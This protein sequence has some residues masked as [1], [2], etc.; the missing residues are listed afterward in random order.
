MVRSSLS[1]KFASCSG[2]TGGLV[3]TLDDDRS[4]A[5]ELRSMVL[6]DRDL[7]FF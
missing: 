2:S 6:R 7:N 5:N 1:N 4:A 3:M